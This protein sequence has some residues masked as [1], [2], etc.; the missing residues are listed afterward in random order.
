LPV[1]AAVLLIALVLMFVHSTMELNYYTARDPR[2]PL[3]QSPTAAD[4]MNVQPYLEDEAARTTGDR[5]TMPILIEKSLHPLASWYA[6]DLRT[7]HWAESLPSSPEER[8][9]MTLV[10]EGNSTPTGYVGQRFRISEHANLDG[11]GWSDWL[12]W[13][14]QRY[15]IGTKSSDLMEIWVKP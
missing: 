8:A 2:E 12:K 11:L 10:Q 14:L 3:N 13:Y 4:M 9:L 5:T 7:V 6:R 1:G 15:E